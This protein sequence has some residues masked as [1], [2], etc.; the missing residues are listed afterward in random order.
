MG[1]S[2]GKCPLGKLR[3]WENSIKIKLRETSCEEWR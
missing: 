1:K 2:L 3:R